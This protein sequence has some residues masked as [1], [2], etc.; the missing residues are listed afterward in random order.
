VIC[1]IVP[2]FSALKEL[3]LAVQAAPLPADKKEITPLS[4]EKSP[5]GNQINIKPGA[6]NPG[7]VRNYNK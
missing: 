1:Q 6:K 4:A 3:L 5:G 7:G 2:F